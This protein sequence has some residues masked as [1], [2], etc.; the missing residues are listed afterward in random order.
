MNS[1]LGKAREIY[2]LIDSEDFLHCDWLTYDTA[3]QMHEVELTF[4]DLLALC[5]ADTEGEPYLE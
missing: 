5:V 4:R 3:C 1:S 2:V